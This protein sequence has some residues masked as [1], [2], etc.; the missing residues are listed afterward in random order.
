MQQH[1]YKHFY[2][3]GHNRFYGDLSVNLIDKTESFQP[4]MGESY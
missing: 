3:K 2:C 1:L 4:K